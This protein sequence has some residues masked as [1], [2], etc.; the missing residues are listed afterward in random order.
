MLGFIFLVQAFVIFSAVSLLAGRIGKL[1]SKNRT[2][3]NHLT[4]IEGAI[5]AVIGVSIAFSK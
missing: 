3:S 5:Y 2:I 4:K 1:L